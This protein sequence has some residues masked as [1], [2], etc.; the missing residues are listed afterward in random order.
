MD[1]NPTNKI[2][3]CFGVGI[4][5]ALAIYCISYRKR[6]RVKLPPGPPLELIVGGLRSLPSTETEQWKVFKDWTQK[7]GKLILWLACAQF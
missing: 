1:I 4:V 2:K 7:W 5:V 3:L 6:Q